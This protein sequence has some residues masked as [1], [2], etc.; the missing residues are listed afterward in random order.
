MASTFNEKIP[1]TSNGLEF[2]GLH[3]RGARPDL[4]LIVLLHG[5]GTT[6]AYFDNSVVSV[7]KDLN[8]LGHNVLNISRPGYGGT[9]VPKTTTP[10]K[11]SIPAFTEFINKVYTD[12]TN[13]TQIEPGIILIGHSI[14]GS[15]ALSVAHEAKDSLPI[16]GVSVMGSLPS[17]EPLDLFP[18]LE[19]E[20]G[21]DAENPRYITEP[22][23]ENIRR[24]MGEVEWL[25]PEALSE[26]VVSA[27]F[28]PGI[29]SEL[30]EYLSPATNSYLLDTVLPNI[31]VPVQFL[32]AEVDI[33]WDNEEQGRPIF[34]DLVKRFTSALRIDAAIL[35]RGGHNYEFC[36][37]VSVLM[38]R[39]GEF[40][41][42]LIAAK[43]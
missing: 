14:G 4:P 40:I 5:G 9:P 27:V 23:A 35:P 7:V 18:G 8:N 24:F 41:A 28:E 31:T 6:P 11:D 22:S 37:N 17:K 1:F 13:I 12:L 38:R 29:K 39:R 26:G 25:H 10:F 33:I 36:R 32:A 16:V 15:L 42:G 21:P 3:K 43:A 34:D 20:N 30:R 19:N 2:Y